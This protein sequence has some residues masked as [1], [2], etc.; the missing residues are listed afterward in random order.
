MG[1]RTLAEPGPTPFGPLSVAFGSIARGN[2]K[3][4]RRSGP[5]GGSFSALVARSNLYRN[6]NRI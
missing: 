1:D 2:V 5:P 4:T 6:I 3:V